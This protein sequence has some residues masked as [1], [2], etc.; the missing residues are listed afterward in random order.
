MQLGRKDAPKVIVAKMK[1]HDDKPIIVET[2]NKL[3]GS[4]VYINHDRTFRER[5]IQSRMYKIAKEEEGKGVTVK[6][7]FKSLR[8]NNEFYIWRKGQGLVESFQNNTRR[9]SNRREH[10]SPLSGRSQRSL[11][12]RSLGY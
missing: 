9:G 5:E 6:I 7:G 12:E 2:E 11:S 8:I 10:S 1:S 3:R 4:K